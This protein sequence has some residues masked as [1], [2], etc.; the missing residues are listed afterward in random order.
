MTRRLSKLLALL[1]VLGAASAVLLP[2]HQLAHPSGRHSLATGPAITHASYHT[3]ATADPENALIS[4]NLASPLQSVPGLLSVSD[5]QPED[6]GAILSNA[7]LRQLHP[8]KIFRVQS[9][10][11]SEAS[12]VFHAH[13]V[14]VVNGKDIVNALV[15]VN[16]DLSNG[17]VLLTVTLLGE[18]RKLALQIMSITACLKS[19]WVD[20]RKSRLASLH[21]TLL[22]R[23]RF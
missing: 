6:R 11:H 19:F 9:A 13:Y 10:Y 22:C 20:L 18:A 16:I 23:I 14:Q 12:N 2:P 15:N 4:F 21:T 3:I 5:D 8:G 7:F 17:H 1:S